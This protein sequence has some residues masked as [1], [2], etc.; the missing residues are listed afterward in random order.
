MK[1]FIL[2][3]GSQFYPK[4]GMFD[5]LGSFDSRDA[6]GVEGVLKYTADDIDWYHVVDTESGMIVENRECNPC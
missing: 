1:R 6:A 4:G 3:G 5:Y 2:F